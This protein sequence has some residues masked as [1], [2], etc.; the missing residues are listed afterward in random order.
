MLD[1]GSAAGIWLSV[2]DLEPYE[3]YSFWIRGCNTQGCVESLP[4]NLTTPPAGRHSQGKNFDIFIR[5]SI[6]CRWQY[7]HFIVA[8]LIFYFFSNKQ[9]ENKGNIE[10]EKVN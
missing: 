8:Q 9:N 1:G 6:K 2:S 10:T 3:N 4:L 5:D 7:Q